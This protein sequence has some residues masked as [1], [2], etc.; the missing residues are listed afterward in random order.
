MIEEGLDLRERDWLAP[1]PHHHGTRQKIIE[2]GAREW[3][4]GENE[5]FV[6]RIR[7]ELRSMNREKDFP[8]SVPEMLFR[9]GQVH[10]LE[11]RTPLEKAYA[12]TRFL[13]ECIEKTQKKG[14]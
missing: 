7:E 5:R 11:P 4:L 1:T 6:T 12:N 14:S 13:I 9:L 2:P 10:G 8:D 3:S